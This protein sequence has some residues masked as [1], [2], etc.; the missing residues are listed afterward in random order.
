MVTLGTIT[1]LFI[2]YLVCF[3]LGLGYWVIAGVFGAFGGIGH[4]IPGHDIGA[5]VSHGGEVNLGGGHDVV[6]G[7]DATAADVGGHAPGDI[8]TEP[9]VS[10]FSPQILSVVLMA[11]GATGIIC[12]EV[13]NMEATSLLPSGAAGIIMGVAVFLLFYLVI[14]KIQGSS[15]PSMRESIGLEAE[16]ITPIPHDAVGEIAYVLRGSRFTARAVSLT[17]GVIGNHVVVQIVKWVGGTAYVKPAD[18]AKGP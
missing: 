14:R 18:D 11:F 15:S 9:A 16:A 1:L 13:F 17:G 10:P 2:A 8:S 4:D 12:H 7:H 3:L 6:A 5:D